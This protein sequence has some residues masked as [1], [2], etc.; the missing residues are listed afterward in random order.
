[1]TS[2]RNSF[3]LKL[4][5]IYSVL[6]VLFVL[7]VLLIFFIVNP[8][9]SAA[10]HHW[11]IANDSDSYISFANMLR[12]GEISQ[13]PFRLPGYPVFLVFTRYLFGIEWLATIMLQQFIAVM[14]AFFVYL[15]AKRYIDKGAI[16]APVIFLLEPATLTNT[17][18]VMPEI[19]MVLAQVLATFIIL[20]VPGSAAR[21]KIV[22][23]I[24]SALVLCAGVFFK[25]I[26]LYSFVVFAAYLLIFAG[27]SLRSRILYAAVFIAV[28]QIPL[29][30]YRGY[31]ES[32]F[33]VRAL[34]RQDFSEK[35]ARSIDIKLLAESGELPSKYAV[36]REF[37]STI[38]S[39]GFDTLKPDYLLYARVCDSITSANIRKFP[40]HM[41]Y[42]SFANS[43]MFFQPATKLSIVFLR[44]KNTRLLP[45]TATV[46]EKIAHLKERTLSPAYIPVVIY[47]VVF[48]A[49]LLLPFLLF[50]FHPKLRAKY[51][52][53]WFF[54]VFW[55]VY[56]SVLCGRITMARYRVTFAWLI[57]VVI[58]LVYSHF[59][60]KQ[61]GNE[62]V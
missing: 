38:Y 26:L 53:I 16:L 59:T 48:S 45:E 39:S 6:G 1:M 3:T 22:L 11:V 19:F 41:A 34:T 8:S 55:F 30:L 61:N 42:Y 46:E 15:I 4:T 60:K 13:F 7:R 40:W 49:V 44:F 58:G 36:S 10:W 25:P 5:S 54:L 43:Y 29:S 51:F 12:A 33:G 32:K 35:A 28:F 37:R 21:H 56:S 50:I 47:S 18:S 9:D 24:A 14:T 20:R 2:G 23:A 27:G 57:A 62:E 31:I 52:P 17:Y